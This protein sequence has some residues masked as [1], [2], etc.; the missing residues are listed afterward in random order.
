[1]NADT[2]Y[3]DPLSDWY[4]SE[5]FNFFKKEK[6]FHHKQEIAGRLCSIL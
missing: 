4:L 1:M 2:K 5:Y 3:D 6:D